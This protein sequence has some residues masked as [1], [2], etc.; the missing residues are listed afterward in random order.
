MS[1]NTVQFLPFH[2]I[3]EFMRADFRLSVIRQ[4]LNLLNKLPD[5]FQDSVNRQIKKSVNVP[6]FRNPEKAPSMVK[7]LPTVKAFEKNPELVS[8]IL[9]AWAENKS[10]L[11]LQVY[12]VLKTREWYLFPEDISSPNNIP[13]LTTEKDWGVLPPTADRNLLPGF[14]IYWPKNQE[15]EAIYKTYTENFPDGDAS[16]DEVSLM[17]VWLANRLPYHIVDDSVPEDDELSPAA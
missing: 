9:S 6:G 10:D 17:A 8:A 16:L 14:L 2:A 5:K 12:Q 15:F 4:T 3:N 11:R 7:V 1:E 13:T